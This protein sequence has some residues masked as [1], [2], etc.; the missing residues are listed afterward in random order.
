[1]S[2][3][4]RTGV[5]TQPS[6]GGQGDLHLL[7]EI[8]VH[9]IKFVKNQQWKAVYLTLLALGGILTL[10]LHDHLQGYVNLLGFVNIVVALA[11][12]VYVIDQHYYLAKYRYRKARIA[13]AL[14]GCFQELHGKKEC[15]CVLRAFLGRDFFLFVVPFCVLIVAVAILN[16]RLVF[17]V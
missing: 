9:D 17:R 3:E 16:W 15:F 5:V 2:D 13:K 1:M 11:G 14:G 12:C 7:F 6:D 4:R 8:C 10:F